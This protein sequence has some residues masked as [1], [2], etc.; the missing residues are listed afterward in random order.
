M[1]N[2]ERLVDA[3]KRFHDQLVVKNDFSETRDS[4]IRD[5]WGIDYM[6]VNR[7]A[8]RDGKLMEESWCCNDDLINTMFDF[9]EWAHKHMRQT[10][11]LRYV[12]IYHRAMVV[13]HAIYAARI[14]ARKAL[15]PETLNWMM[16]HEFEF[17]L[18][19]EHN[20]HQYY[21]PDDSLTTKVYKTLMS[22]D[23]LPL[24]VKTLMHV[25]LNCVEDWREFIRDFD[26]WASRQIDI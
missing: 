15:N 24:E 1:A 13:T 14:A 22:G 8:F 6:R 21:K 4:F 16:E 25:R 20:A 10:D 17:D 23:K 26:N 12:H 19:I 2:S 11:E 7:S 3:L 5:H 9:A 18:N